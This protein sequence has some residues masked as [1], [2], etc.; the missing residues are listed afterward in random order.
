[1]H[2]TTRLAALGAALA[3]VLPV[4]GTAHADTVGSAPSRVISGGATGLSFPA[5]VTR[6]PG[7]QWYVANGGGS[8]T[9]YASG[10]NG[11]ATPVRTIAGA[12]TGL[13]GSTY[14]VAVDAGGFVY[15]TSNNSI[16][17]FAPD[18]TGNVFPVK[19]ISGPATGLA[20]PVGLVV[21]G[22]GSVAVANYGASSVLRFAPTASGNAAPAAVLAGAATGL[23]FP[24]D[25]VVTRTGR[26][27]VLNNLGAVNVFGHLANGN[28]APDRTIG[29]LASGITSAYGL[30]VDSAENVY[31]STFGQNKIVVFRSGATGN[32]SPARVLTGA[33]TQLNLPWGVYVGA[34][35]R[36]TVASYGGN[37][38]DTFAPLMALPV[39]TPPT[40]VRSLVVHGGARAKRRPITWAAPARNGGAPLIRY[41]LVVKK[42]TKVVRTARLAPSQ[43]SFVLRTRTLKRGRYV[44]LVRAVNAKGPGPYAAAALRIRK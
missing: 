25:L 38:V 41:E 10:A 42:G 22:D 21:L 12:N 35:R 9:V 17:V 32:A 27:Y 3:L 23:S 33:A 18:A 37:A 4:T 11:N 44:V 19:V 29:G 20:T 6:G 8:I 36:L 40:V 14:D 39:V 30:A 16:R 26:L 2:V 28:L 1:M 24:I 15:A 7:G 5:G 31:V 43:G 34:D 13:T